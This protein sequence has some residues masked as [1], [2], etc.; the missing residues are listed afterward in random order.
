MAA[1]LAEACGYRS[2]LRAH[3]RPGLCA[4]CASR[5][6]HLNLSDSSFRVERDAHVDAGLQSMPDTARVVV[7]CNCTRLEG[8][9]SVVGA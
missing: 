1:L 8:R 7:V 9:K 4:V 5:A 3:S 6:L 2:R